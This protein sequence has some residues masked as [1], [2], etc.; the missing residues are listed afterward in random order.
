MCRLEDCF[1]AQVF[2]LASQE[3]LSLAPLE[4]TY[5]I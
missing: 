3:E 1:A 4:G 2:R 5:T